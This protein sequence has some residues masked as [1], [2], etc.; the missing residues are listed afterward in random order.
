MTEPT[1]KEEFEK[2]LNHLISI[3]ELCY[4][5]YA[6]MKAKHVTVENFIEKWGS[7]DDS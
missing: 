4:G 5:A 6:P 2:D 3:V 1:R 7:A